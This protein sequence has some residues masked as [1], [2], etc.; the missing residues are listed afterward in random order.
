[1]KDFKKIIACIMA[2][3]T[4]GSLTYIN[5]G[6]VSYETSIVDSSND[7]YE[8]SSISIK[9]DTKESTVT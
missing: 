4:L 9:R 7:G 5:A 2:V 3:A 6:A 1:M 8:L